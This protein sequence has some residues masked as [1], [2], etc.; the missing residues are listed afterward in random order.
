MRRSEYGGILRRLGIAL[1]VLLVCALVAMVMYLLAEI[2]NRRYRLALSDRQLIVE[3]GRFFPA[4]FAAYTP[5]ARNLQEAYA[6]ILVPP[7]ESVEVGI[8]FDDRTEIDRA[9]YTRLSGWARSRLQASDGP[10]LTLG[11]D[12]VKR[13]EALPGLSESQRQELR[14]MRADAA[15]R[16]GEGL[17][18]GIALTL[19]HAA[20][21]FALA[22]ELG[23]SHSE[24]ARL[25]MAA[26]DDKLRQLGEAPH[27]DVPTATGT[28]P[29]Y[30][31]EGLHTPL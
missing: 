3:R 28:P 1:V 30:P 12:Y 9:L 14:G 22:L 29:L 7:G 16:Q 11:I 25:G 8:P 6:P 24:Q 5:E 10:T 20:S 13:L 23:T 27:P 18:R 17:M 26:I 4:G 31:A 21:Q 19:H 15:F 2:N